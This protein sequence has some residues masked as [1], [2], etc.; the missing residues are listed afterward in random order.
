MTAHSQSEAEA[1]ARRMAARAL[2][3]LDPTARK[4]ARRDAKYSGEVDIAA[5]W[6]ARHDG[7][8]AGQFCSLQRNRR[9]LMV[10]GP[11]NLG[12]LRVDPSDAGLDL[13]GSRDDDP[14]E[15]LCALEGAAAAVLAAG[16]LEAALAWRH[17]GQVSATEHAKA[18]NLGLRAGQMS[19]KAQREVDP[20]QLDLFLSAGVQE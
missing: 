10:G 20:R 15:A 11:D 1:L 6:L 18:C 7:L 17:P 13:F 8:T 14:L 12:K 19:L 4:M 3:A 2:A 16:G 5:A 9:R